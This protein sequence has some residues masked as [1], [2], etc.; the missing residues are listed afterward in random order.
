MADPYDMRSNIKGKP[1]SQGTLFQVKDKGLLN[2][3]QRWPQG[4][5]PERLNEVRGALRETPVS[6]PKWMGH[7]PQDEVQR[8]VGFNEHGFREHV[9]RE[10]AKTT[11]PAEHLRGLTGIHGDPAEGTHGTYWKGPGR[12]ELAVD[13][14]REV[15]S[16]GNVDKKGAEPRKTLVH[17]IGHHVNMTLAPKPHEHDLVAQIHAHEDIKGNEYR[18][19]PNSSDVSFARSRIRAGVDEA[20]ADTYLVEHYRTGGRKS[21]G[22]QAGA[23]EENFSAQDRAQRYP[24]YNDL[25]PP[26]NTPAHQASRSALNE[27]QFN[28]GLFSRSQAEGKPQ[29]E[30]QRRLAARQNAVTQAVGPVPQVTGDAR[31]AA[32]TPWRNK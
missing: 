5:S 15:D 1:G 3:Q 20:Q 14:T 19:K 31:R 12:R 32:K 24:G 17:E 22:T 11:V 26:E 23:Y 28:P 6:A 16:A 13:M 10:I 7:H 4:Y 9:T 21:T 18:D 8:E 29:S 25:R 2:P 30:L 27:R